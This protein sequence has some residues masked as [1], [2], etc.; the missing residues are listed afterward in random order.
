[1]I[2][3]YICQQNTIIKQIGISTITSTK[4]GKNYNFY[5]NTFM[6]YLYIIV[7]KLKSHQY[8]M[9]L[10]LLKSIGYSFEKRCLIFLCYFMFCDFA[11]FI[12]D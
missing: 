6:A 12:V 2:H 10:N 8:L 7:E 5:P 11:H 1:M 9:T 4:K 3:K